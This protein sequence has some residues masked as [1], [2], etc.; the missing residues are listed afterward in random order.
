MSCPYIVLLFSAIIKLQL[1]WGRESKTSVLV[2]RRSRLSSSSDRSAKID[3]KV[4][5]DEMEEEEGFRV[6]LKKTNGTSC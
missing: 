4:K 1:D 3:L 2:V 5:C 6:P